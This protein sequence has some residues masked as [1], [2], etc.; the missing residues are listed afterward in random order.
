APVYI[1]NISSYFLNHPFGPKTEVSWDELERF[2][3]SR[4]F[5]KER[6]N[7][8]ELLH[9][10]GVDSYDPWQIIRKTEGRMCEDHMWLKIMEE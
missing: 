3:E 6:P 2:L 8:K 5:P 1:K 10:L 7:C 4:C 9:L